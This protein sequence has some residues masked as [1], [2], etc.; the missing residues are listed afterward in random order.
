[1]S[2]LLFESLRA[3]KQKLFRLSF[4]RGQ[5]EK[6]Y[7]LKTR[8]TLTFSLLVVS[9]RA[10]LFFSLI[11]KTTKSRRCKMKATTPTPTNSTTLLFRHLFSRP[12]CKTPNSASL[13]TKCLCLWPPLTRCKTIDCAWM[14]RRPTLCGNTW[15]T[16]LPS[17]K[18]G[19]WQC[20]RTA[21]CLK[22]IC[23][24]RWPAETLT[25][26]IFWASCSTAFRWTPTTRTATRVIYWAWPASKRCN[27]YCKHVKWNMKTWQ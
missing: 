24:T 21:M 19:S 20:T 1:M 12:I 4:Q 10:A 3:I 2:S 6:I 11:S 22:R 8:N 18:N 14:W 17:R 25:S 23:W 16:T 15:P 7:T 13:L 27:Q 5:G 9:V 26:R